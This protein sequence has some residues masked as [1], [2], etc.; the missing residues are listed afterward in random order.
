[1]QAKSVPHPEYSEYWSLPL[2]LA[3]MTWLEWASAV[4]EYDSTLVWATSFERTLHFWY[5]V[6]EIRLLLANFID[7]I[8]TSKKSILFVFIQWDHLYFIHYQFMIVVE[9]IMI[10]IIVK[11][12]ENDEI[13]IYDLLSDDAMVFLK[14]R[15]RM[16]YKRFRMRLLEI[17]LYICLIFW[18]YYVQTWRNVLKLIGWHSVSPLKLPLH[19]FTASVKFSGDAKCKNATELA[20]IRVFPHIWT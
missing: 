11:C 13:I 12:M 18:Y 4:C 10:I 3:R 9:K 17:V 5:T 8:S 16:K 19:G 20:D 1:M 15:K 7:T 14:Q 2:T 6:S